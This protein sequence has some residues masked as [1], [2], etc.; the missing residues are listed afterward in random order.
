MRTTRILNLCFLC[1]TLLV[2]AFAGSHT[3]ERFQKLEATRGA[4]SEAKEQLDALI[5][6]TVAKRSSID[7]L[8]HDPEYVEKMIRQKLNYAKPE[9]TV[10]KF[11]YDGS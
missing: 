8:K 2:G 5:S 10:F 9:E 1:A 7:K 11:E 4:E 6:K 3:W